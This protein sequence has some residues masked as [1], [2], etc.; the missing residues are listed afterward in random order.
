MIASITFVLRLLSSTAMTTNKAPEIHMTV[1]EVAQIAVNLTGARDTWEADEIMDKIH[2]KDPFTKWIMSLNLHNCRIGSS[3]YEATD[4]KGYR[5]DDQCEVDS[6][7]E[8]NEKDMDSETRDSYTEKMGHR[9]VRGAIPSHFLTKSPEIEEDIF[10][11][12]LIAKMTPVM[13]AE[14]FQC[15]YDITHNSSFSSILLNTIMEK[16]EKDPLKYYSLLDSYDNREIQLM[17]EILPVSVVNAVKNLLSWVREEDLL[18][19]CTEITILGSSSPLGLTISS[20]D[21]K[22]IKRVF[23]QLECKIGSNIPFYHLWLWNI[24]FS[25]DES[26][27]S[28]LPHNKISYIS[29]IRFEDCIFK[30]RVFCV[31]KREVPDQ[32]LNLTVDEQ[33]FLMRI[34]Q[35]R[36]NKCQI[37]KIDPSLKLLSELVLFNIRCF[38]FESIPSVVCQ[39]KKL[40]T[41]K[42]RNGNLCGISDEIRNLTDLKILTIS[43]NRLESIPASVTKMENLVELIIGCNRITRITNT[44]KDMKSLRLLI[45]DNNNINADECSTDLKLPNL[46]ILSM[47]NCMLDKLPEFVNRL[48]SLRVLVCMMNEITTFNEKLHIHLNELEILVASPN[49]FTTMPSTIENMKNL[50]TLVIGCNIRGKTLDIDSFNPPLGLIKLRL[51]NS[52][53]KRGI[54]DWVFKLHNLAEL[55]MI[56]CNIETVPPEIAEL[57]NLTK[58][59][60]TKCNLVGF[61]EEITKLTEL[62]FLHLGLNPNIKRISPLIN[63][64]QKLETFIIYDSGLEDELCTEVSQLVRLEYINLSNNSLKSIP[65]EIGN[66]KFLKS[67]DMH[68]NRQLEELPDTISNMSSLV[69]IKA[70]NCDLKYI[71]DAIGNLKLLEE[72]NIGMNKR[73]TKIP[74]SIGC[75]YRLQ[76]IRFNGMGL[77]TPIHQ[78]QIE[79]AIPNS[80]FNL[81][82]LRELDLACNT[83]LRVFSKLSV[84]LRSLRKLDISKCGLKELPHEI[85]SLQQLQELKAGINGISVLSDDIKNLKHLKVLQLFNNH[86]KSLPQSLRYLNKLK[87]L[88]IR[89]NNFPQRYRNHLVNLVNDL[90]AHSLKVY[91]WSINPREDAEN[92]QNSRNEQ[93]CL[94]QQPVIGDSSFI[95]GHP[96]IIQHPAINHLYIN[97]Y[98]YIN[99]LPIMYGQPPMIANYWQYQV[100]MYPQYYIVP[101][102]DTPMS[103]TFH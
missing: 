55:A 68:C 21:A 15:C 91:S 7:T 56:K 78:S 83:K 93:V 99:Q 10:L 46:K 33:E 92:I 40:T 53:S 1:K 32:Q 31:I 87:V 82:N 50:T 103:W 29:R 36:I 94:V 79:N 41:L 13:F 51:Y 63:K 96:C 5:D 71:P 30:D 37:R 62:K 34:K 60:L 3:K 16:S 8:E 64:L 38:E 9:A 19:R 84:K 57:K 95:H 61:P 65:S 43:R 70:T 69:I 35:L 12:D 72:L 28:Y 24:D 80:F 101:Y 47:K 17:D 20:C 97:G 100:P 59:K 58:L 39:M 102:I 88:D 85:F 44:M 52:K 73:I 23:D 74:E 14:F 48:T 98:P 27:F 77:S 81:N 54:P 22:D 2:K 42:L 90:R 18:Q 26:P 25:Q 76:R 75:L 4:R 89:P 45:L 86:L 6:S 66:M 49:N 11:Y 67:I